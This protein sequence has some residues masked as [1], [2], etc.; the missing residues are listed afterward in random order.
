MKKITEFQALMKDN[1]KYKQH[2]MVPFE[3]STLGSLIAVIKNTSNYHLSKISENH[4]ELLQKK[5]LLWPLEYVFPV[6]DLVRMTLMHSSMQPFFGSYERGMDFFAN[7]IRCIKSE[8]SDALLITTLRCMC[9][10]YEGPSTTYVI[11]RMFKLILSQYDIILEHKAKNV[12]N[13][14]IALLLKYSNIKL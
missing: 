6:I 12:V 5:L 9:N 13:H 14:G 11:T 4:L 1:P 3:E 8:S 10:M 7:I 2:V